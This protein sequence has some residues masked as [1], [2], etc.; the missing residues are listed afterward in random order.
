VQVF[1]NADYTTTEHISKLLGRT[2]VMERQDV[3]VSAS[4]LDR[5]DLG[6]REVP[7]TVNLLDPFELTRWFARE[8]GRQLLLVPGRPPLFLE[9]MDE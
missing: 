5:G 6:M 3:R 1:G 7:R 8:T 2:V 4:G 9:R